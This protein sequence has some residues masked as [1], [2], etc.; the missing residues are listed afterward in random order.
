MH[1]TK[2][3]LPR[4]PPHSVSRSPVRKTARKRR[5]RSLT[6]RQVRKGRTGQSPQSIHFWQASNG[7]THPEFVAKGCAALGEGGI[8]S[9]HGP[10]ALFGA[11]HAAWNRTSSARAVPA[12]SINSAAATPSLR[13]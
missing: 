1:A 12:S 2:L 4:R 3:P 11:D 5:S 13:K 8:P 6:K 7:G 10:A 9:P